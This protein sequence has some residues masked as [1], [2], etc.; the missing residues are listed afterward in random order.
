MRGDRRFLASNRPPATSTPGSRLSRPSRP[1]PPPA[2]AAPGRRGSTRSTTW[3]SWSLGT[4]T[5]TSSTLPTNLRMCSDKAWNHPEPAS[6]TLAVHP[7]AIDNFAWITC[8]PPSRYVRCG[9][10]GREFECSWRRECKAQ[11]CSN[12]T[13]GTGESNTPPAPVLSKCDARTFLPHY[14]GQAPSGRKL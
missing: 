9:Y 4:S 8:T 5:T 3:A 6:A 7:N 12:C 10:C 14:P 2:T 1:H 13:R 11:R